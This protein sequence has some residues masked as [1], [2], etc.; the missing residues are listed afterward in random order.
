[1]KTVEKRIEVRTNSDFHE[2][3]DFTRDSADLDVSGYQSRIKLIAR[4]GSELVSIDGVPDQALTKRHWYDE[5][6]ASM[7]GLPLTGGVTW[8]L[9]TIDTDGK[10]QIPMGGPVDVKGGVLYGV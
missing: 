3:I 7:A 4:D 1:M 9:F 5:L 10:L 8:L 6:Q 2:F